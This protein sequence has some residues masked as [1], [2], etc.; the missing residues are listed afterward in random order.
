MSY[1]DQAAIADNVSMTKRV[2]QCAAQQQIANPDDWT[3]VHRRNW[4]ASP[5]WDEAWASAL[6][7]HEDNPTYDPGA[8]ESVITDAMILSEVQALSAA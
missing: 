5:G 7:S 4:A 6:A 2:A 3:N 1:L 8:D